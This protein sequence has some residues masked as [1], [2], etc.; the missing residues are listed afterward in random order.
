[1]R[2]K[3]KVEMLFS[4]K[5]KKALCGNA[6]KKER[7]EYKSKNKKQKAFWLAVFSSFKKVNP[8][9][10]KYYF[11]NNFCNKET[12][13]LFSELVVLK[14]AKGENR[15]QRM[16]SFDDQ[17]KQMSERIEKF[18][19]HSPVTR[20]KRIKQLELL[21]QRVEKNIREKHRIITNITMKNYPVMNSANFRHLM[22]AS[23]TLLL[24]ELEFFQDILKEVR[25][26]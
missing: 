22:N 12:R 6:S 10:R 24:S 8:Q 21:C 25:E 7:V 13:K 11:L 5:K 9:N 17:L 23:V 18:V 14:K 15:E 2:A 19:G 4:G 16:K 20:D 1:M 26:E 3:R